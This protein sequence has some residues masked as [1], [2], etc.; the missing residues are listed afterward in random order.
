MIA[1]RKRSFRKHNSFNP[2]ITVILFPIEPRTDDIGT[3]QPN[4]GGMRR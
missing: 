1:E 4:G 2:N 3:N